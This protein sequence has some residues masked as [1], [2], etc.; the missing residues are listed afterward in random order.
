MRN[1]ARVVTNAGVTTAPLRGAHDVV[2]CGIGA[3]VASETGGTT[4]PLRGEKNAGE[5]EVGAHDAL[6]R[7]EKIAR[8]NMIHNVRRLHEKVTMLFPRP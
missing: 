6:A 1:G 4:T 2:E 3:R 7:G 8:G 5:K